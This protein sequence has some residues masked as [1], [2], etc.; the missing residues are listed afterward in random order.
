MPVPAAGQLYKTAWLF[1]LLLAVLAVLWIGL[2]ERP[3]S[4]CPEERLC[5]ALFLSPS[6]WVQ[7]LAAGA[8]GALL[9]VG[10][11]E[12]A[13]RRLRVAGA[14]ENQLRSLLGN[15]RRDEAVAIALLSG[16]AEEL[17]FR[18]ALQGSVG[19]PLA[20]VLFALLHTGPG[21]ALRFWSVF[22]LLAGLL[23]AGLLVWRGNLL[24]PITAH[25]LVNGI[26]LWRMT[27][28]VE[29]KGEAPARQ[30]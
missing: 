17:F 30:S 13:R 24:A 11:W 22:A 9:V 20:T 1:Y 14:L 2:D 12:L 26:G 5:G 18:G 7:D 10:F 27:A 28:Q 21:P 6:S 29:G 4:P 23:F 15:L 19:W 25:I 8:A 3:N 16:F